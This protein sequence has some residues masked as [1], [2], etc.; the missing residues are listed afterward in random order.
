MVYRFNQEVFDLNN[1]DKQYTYF[2]LNDVAFKT[3]VDSLLPFYKTGKADSTNKLASMKVVR[4]A[5][6]EGLYPVSQLP[7][8]LTSKFGVS[9]PV[10]RNAIIETRRVSNGIVHIVNR[11]NFLTKQKIDSVYVQGEVPVD[12]FRPTGERINVRSSTFFRIRTDSAT[13]QPFNDIFIYN[14]GIAA[15]NVLYRIPNLPSA[16]YKVYWKALNDTIRVS[17]NT[18]NP[19]SFT[20]RLAMGSR[21]ATNFPYI[22]VGF[23]TF[24]EIPLTP[25]YIHAS[26]GTLDIYLTAANVTTAGAN[27]LTLDYIKLVPVIP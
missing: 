4:D 10:D 3:E 12:F 8:S 11:L 16:R 13:K 26:Y 1:E 25:D 14:H 6:V 5:V 18:I 23:N 9:I 24:A 15:L 27:S 20:Q 21:T 19:V 17:S 22:T 7:A 2:V